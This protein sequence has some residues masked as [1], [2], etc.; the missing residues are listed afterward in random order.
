MRYNNT[1]KYVD[2]LLSVNNRDIIFYIKAIYL[3][4]LEVSNTNVDPL[5]KKKRSFLDLDIEIDDGKFTS[6]VCD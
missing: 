2:D 6:K 3:R 5:K 1:F 4:D